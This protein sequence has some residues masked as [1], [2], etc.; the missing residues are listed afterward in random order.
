[1]FKFRHRV[2]S[3]GV[4]ADH[5]LE[6]RQQRTA[7]NHP[8]DSCHDDGVRA[9]YTNSLPLTVF[10][11]PRCWGRYGDLSLMVAALGPP[12][13]GPPPLPLGIATIPYNCG[14]WSKRKLNAVGEPKRRLRTPRSR[15]PAVFASAR[16][17]NRPPRSGETSV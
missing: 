12:V 10:T 4:H 9:T 5:E 8:G 6:S 13:P 16:G 14:K 3:Y 7:E 17:G 11:Q 15:L 2:P 1:M